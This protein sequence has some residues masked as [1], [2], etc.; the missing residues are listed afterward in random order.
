MAAHNQ[1]VADP[2]KSGGIA[3][4]QVENEKSL[5][6]SSPEESVTPAPEHVTLKTWLVIF[7]SLL[8]SFL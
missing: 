5:G 3:T 8:P 1:E 6:D 2:A 7:V 4:S